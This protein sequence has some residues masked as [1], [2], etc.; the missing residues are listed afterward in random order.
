[1]S[2]IIRAK[3]ILTEKECEDIN[4]CFTT[5]D[6]LQKINKKLILKNEKNFNL[7]MTIEQINYK[8][9]FLTLEYNN[10]LIYTKVFSASKKNIS[11]LSVLGIINFK[12]TLGNEE[13]SF[14][15]N[16]MK[17]RTGFVAYYKW[18]IEF[19][20]YKFF[21]ELIGINFQEE[22]KIKY[23]YALNQII[24]SDF[25]DLEDFIIATW[26]LLAIP[27]EYNDLIFNFYE[28]KLTYLIGYD[29]KYFFN[30]DNS[31]LIDSYI[32]EQKKFVSL[33]DILKYLL[34]YVANVKYG[35]VKPSIAL[36]DDI[37]KDIFLF[38]L[39]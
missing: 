1:M 37:C 8:E 4:S 13:V 9:I 27:I 26:C 3:G 34:G 10:R 28:E 11:V 22:M 38:N 36:I 24:Y 7:K 5:N 23:N 32:E 35:T 19:L 30:K 31:Y 29:L 14:I 16:I 6:K 17:E 12:E 20:W 2:K 18:V 25:N 39:T 21:T 33:N 15:I